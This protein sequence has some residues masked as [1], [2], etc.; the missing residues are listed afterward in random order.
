MQKSRLKSSEN[1]KNSRIFQVVLEKDEK[2]V[3]IYSLDFLCSD[4]VSRSFFF[5]SRNR[6]KCFALKYQGNHTT[7]FFNKIFEPI[8]SYERVIEFAK[9][10]FFINS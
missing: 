7:E 9:D 5:W 4:G 1:L 8:Y 10:K 6:A 2:Q 3:I